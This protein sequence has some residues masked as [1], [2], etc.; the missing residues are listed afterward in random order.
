[1][2]GTS[3]VPKPTVGDL[4]LC[5]GCGEVLQFGRRLRLQR[6]TA[7]EIT[8]LDPETAA[9]LRQTQT[10]VRAFLARRAPPPRND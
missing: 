5:F 3:P 2:L 9:D 1:M 6:I 8:A 4:A 7:A 10:L